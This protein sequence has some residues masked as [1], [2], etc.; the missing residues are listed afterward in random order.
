MSSQALITHRRGKH[1]FNFES[2]KKSRGRPKKEDQNE[3][4]YQNALNNYNEFL[5]QETRK[6]KENE[7]KINL[8]T[9]KENLKTFSQKEKIIYLKIL[10]KLK[11]ILFIN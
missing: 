11:N 10:I 2:E 7:E 3:N 4:C 6:I 9:I 5:N 1:G 8:D